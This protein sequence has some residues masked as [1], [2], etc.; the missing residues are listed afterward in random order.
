MPDITLPNGEVLRL[1]AITPH[2]F[3]VRK[4][5]DGCFGEAGLVRYGILRTEWPAVEASITEE[6]TTFTLSTGQASLTVCKDTGSTRLCR[7]DGSVLVRQPD[8]TSPQQ[9]FRAEFSL[10]AEDRLYGLGDE[11]RDRLNKRGHQTRMIV[12]NVASYAPLPFLMSTGGWAVFLNSTWF[13]QVDAGATCADRLVFSADQGELDYYLIVGETLPVLLDRYTELTGRPALLPQF[14]YGLTWVCDERGVRARDV[15]YEAHMFRREGIPLDIVGLEPDWMETHYDFSV[16]KEWSKERFHQPFWM[17]HQRP[18][19]FTAALRNMGFKLS[20]WLCCDYDVTEYE[21][22]LLAPQDAKP[23]ATAISEDRYDED[24]VKDPHFHPA[25]QDRITKLGEP[26]FAHLRKFVDNG[27]AAFKMDGSNQICFHPDRKWRNGMEDAEVHNLYPVLLAKQMS[28]GF[29]EHTA[30][31]AMIYT[32]GGYTGVQQY[33]ATWAGDTGGDAKPLVSLLNHG[34]SGHSNTSCDMQVWNKAGIHFGFLQPWSQILCWHQYN[35]PW[36]LPPEIYEVFKFYA[37]LRYRLLPYLY[38]A[39]HVAHRTGMPILRAMPL[40]APED[41]RSDELILQYMLGEWLLTCAFTDTIYLPAG[42]WTDY[43][44]GEIHEGPQ[45]LRYEP[46]ADR[47]GPLFVKA[48]AL[49]PTWP[50]MDYVGQR[51]VETMGLE[52][53]PHEDSGFTLYEDD[54]ITEAYREGQVATTHITCH[55]RDGEV[56]VDLGPRVGRYEGM[57]E[58]RLWELTLHLPE[59]ATRVFV[60]GQE[61]SLETAEAA[62][63]VLRTSVPEGQTR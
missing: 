57:P 61:Q 35:Q 28:Q 42:K 50:P 48:G 4:S 51:S 41:P 16:N 62:T 10:A 52:I 17:P 38:S 21:E 2:M 36:F 60:N 31:R 34:L 33:A 13:H 44:T 11:T 47:G 26:W 43:W 53:F 24:I 46:P 45:E 29:V 55:E 1:E 12:R 23:G 54:G 37:R 30:R 40:V 25:Y 9:G 22:Q 18:G 3:R 7:A 32:A 19:G 14:G 39:A 49:L 5:R 27:A 58:R 15:L 56:S 63:G 6:G 20:L 59:G 8:A